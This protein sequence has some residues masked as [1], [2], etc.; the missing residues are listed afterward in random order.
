M[1]SIIFSPFHFLLIQVKFK[2]QDRMDATVNR[3]HF[4]RDD[5][6]SA[7]RRWWDVVPTL[8]D[9]LSKETTTTAQQLLSS[10]HNFV[11]LSPNK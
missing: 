10:S 7:R 5:F 11:N 6:G 9:P 4:A 8:T 2:I 3:S 1:L